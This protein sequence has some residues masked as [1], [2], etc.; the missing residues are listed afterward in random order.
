MEHLLNP[1]SEAAPCGEYLK[2]NRSL[3][4]G[5]RNSFNMAQ[6][7][8]RQL[9]ESPDAMSNEELLDANISH[10]SEL[11]QQSEETLQ[12]T[13]KDTEVFCWLATAQ[14]FSNDPLSNLANVLEVFAESVDRFWDNLN[15]KPP[16][17]KL[18]AGDESGQ[19]QEWAEYRVKPLLQLIGDTHDSGLL[20]MPLQLIE[21][22]GG[23][24]YSRYFSAERAGELAQLKEDAQTAINN[25]KDQV[26]HTVL[27]LGRCMDAL[28]LMEQNVNLHCQQDGATG[29]SFRFVK[30]S[31]ERLLNAI[32]YLTGDHLNPWPLDKVEQPEPDMVSGMRPDIPVSE[33][34]NSTSDVSDQIPTASISTPQ[35]VTTIVTTSDI[36]NRDQAFQ[37]LRMISDYLQQTE[38]HSPVY[39]LLERA[40]RWGYMPLPELLSEMVG[41][42]AQVM[43]RITQLAGLETTD[44][45]TLPDNPAPIGSVNSVSANPAPNKNVP[46]PAKMQESTETSVRMPEE[47]TVDQQKEKETADNGSNTSGISSFKW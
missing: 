4:R 36:V 42:N 7:S 32:R 3:Y 47:D 9:I 12:Q 45:T 15:P 33:Q 24:D 37:Q 39:M 8:F 30:E 2:G 25:E 21:L 5:L 29:V 16:V 41:D 19:K 17:E 10:W 18:K 11:R 6:S 14:L 22:V 40:I 44:K 26:I 27:S 46:E 31:V 35:A 38:P 20:Y 28:E 34:R 43:G 23:I 13:S 1:I